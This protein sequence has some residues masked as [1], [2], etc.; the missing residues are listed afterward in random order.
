MPFTLKSKIHLNNGVSM[1]FIGLGVY[2][3]RSGRETYQAVKAALETGYRLVD[4]ASMYRNEEDVGRAIKDS[5][6]PREEVFVTTKLWNDDHG[7]DSALRA[8]DTSLKRL[9]FGYID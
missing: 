2:L 8:F 4:T 3:M 6:V 7:Y 1:P 9:G 5:A